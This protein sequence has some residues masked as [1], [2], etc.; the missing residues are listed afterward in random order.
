[1]SIRDLRDQARNDLHAELA[2]P[3]HY[4]SA[5]RQ[6]VLD[7]T[8]R[9]HSNELRQGNLT[10]FGLDGPAELVS[11]AP[12]IVCLVAQVTPERGGVFAVSATEMYAVETP[13]VQDGITYKVEVST[14]QADQIAREDPALTYPGAV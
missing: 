9:H 8:I 1:M 11:Q 14:M 2:F 5:D 13:P 3:A 12:E 6:T 10:G 7:C 4:H